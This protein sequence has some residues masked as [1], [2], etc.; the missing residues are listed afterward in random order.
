MGDHDAELDELIDEHRE[1]M[2][3]MAAVR[4]AAGG[5]GSELDSLL[6]QLETALAHH[7]AGKSAGCS[8]S[9]ATWRFLRTTSAS[10]NTTTR[11]SSTSSTRHGLTGA[12]L[13]LYSTV[14]KR[15]WLVRRTTCSLPPSNC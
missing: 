10:S 4:R 3:I 9:S 2:S 14:S 1:L 6:D 5:P 12:A 8:M 13:T 7:T 11:T 15:I